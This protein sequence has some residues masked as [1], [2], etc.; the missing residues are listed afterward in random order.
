MEQ[1][2]EVDEEIAIGLY[3]ADAFIEEGA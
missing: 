1:G 3:V 2:S